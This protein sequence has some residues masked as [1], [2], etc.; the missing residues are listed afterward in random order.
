[1]KAVVMDGYGGSD[2]LHVREVA[3]PVAQPGEV[4]IRVRAAGVNPVDWKIRRGDIRPFV[5]RRFPFIPGGD[6]AGEVE[7]VG[8]GAKRFRP[9]AAVFTLCGAAR[10]GGY[11][12]FVAVKEE[13][14]ARKPEAWSF[15]EAAAV[16][17]AG[18]T[19]LQALRDLGG[20]GEGQSTLVNG[21]S[22]GVG[23]LAVPI[24]RA[25]GARVVAAT[26]GPRNV[27]FVR[28]LG[29]DPVLDYTRDDFTRRSDMYDVVFDAVATSS[30][31]ACRL[32]LKPA[33]T[34][35][36]TLPSPSVLFWS[37]AQAVRFGPHQRARFVHV[38]ASGVDLDYLARLADDGRLRPTLD[39]VL[40]LDQVREAHTAS[41]GG[42]TRGKIVLKID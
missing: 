11:A 40:P 10:G 41:E 24:A 19:A 13:L 27:D 22:G 30:F 32:V 2:V 29:A 42:H 18:L 7:A 37:A 6:V 36:A 3:T 16:P 26:C 28:S 20:L 34:Y 38:K 15:E 25:L 33:G 8:E 31:P 23:H 35:I 1:M 5:P 21:A 9:G 39:R 14:L 12:E 17:I 4:L